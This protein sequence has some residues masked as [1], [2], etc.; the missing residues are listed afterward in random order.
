MA[1]L[2]IRTLDFD[3]FLQIQNEE[4]KRLTAKDILESFKTI[5]FVCLTNHGLPQE[6]VD[7]MFEWSKKFFSLPMES[8]MLA[9]HPPSGTHHRGYSA[10]GVE[11]VGKSMDISQASKSLPTTSD[12]KESFECG[13]EDDSLMP[14]I[15]LPEDVL[16]GFREVCLDFYWTCYELEKHILRA[17]AIAFDLAEDYFM[18]F[19]REVDNQLRLLHYP[20]VS[21]QHGEDLSRIAAHTDYDTFTLLFQDD[22][23]GLEVEDPHRPGIF[24]NQCQ[25]RLWLT[26][27]TS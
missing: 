15:W 19:H 26:L 4:L 10:P 11:Q 18:P 22:V 24:V 3:N 14:N 1:A 13:K 6:K 8:K 7:K 27:G 23:G 5:G 20:S 16:P 21:Y 2:S 12:I 25:M 9:P 17:L